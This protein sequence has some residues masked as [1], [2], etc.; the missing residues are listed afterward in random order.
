MP[1]YHP[2]I[3]RS[4]FEAL[5][6]SAPDAI[7]TIDDDSIV[8]SVNAAV[9]RVFGYTP[10]E[11]IGKSLTMLIPERLRAAHEGGIARYIRTG[12]KNIPWTG[13][14]LPGLTKDGREIPLE[15]SFG[16]FQDEQGRRVFS[17]FARD[18]SERARQQRELE[19]ARAVAENA[20]KELASVDRVMNIAMASG[21]YD[22][23]MRELVRGLRQEL[24]ADEATVLLTDK[25]QRELTIQVADGIEIGADVRIP[26][27]RGL[28]GRVAASG[29]PL[30]IEDLTTMEV[31]NPVLRAEIASLMAVPLRSDGELIGVV[32]VGTRARRQF[33]QFDVR[34]LEIVAERLSGVMAR[35]RLNAALEQQAREERILRGLAQSITAAGTVADAM[36]EIAEGA[37][38]LSEASGAFIEQVIA[39]N[40]DVEV[41]ASSGES[42]PHVGQRV[43]Y[44]GSLTEEIIKTRKPVFLLRLEGLGA[45]MAPYL[46]ERCHGCSA[47]VVP[48]FSEQGVLG[49]LVLLRRPGEPEF[50]QTVL[51]R[52]STLADLASLSLQRLVALAES[53]RR[54]GEA[55]AAVRSR[56]DVLSVVSHDLRNPLSTIAMSASLLG[57]RDIPLSADQQRK[58]VEI[59]GRSAQRMNRLIQDLLDVARI[60]GG[61]LAM[62]CRCEDVLALAREAVDAFRPIAEEKSLVLDCQVPEDAGAVLADRDRVLQLLSNFLNNAVKFSPRAGRITLRV[63]RTPARAVRFDVEDEGPG[64]AADHIPHVFGRFWQEKRTAHMG[65]GLGL[66]IARGIA[67]AHKGRVWVE[68]T[69]GRGSVFSFEL[70]FTE[71]C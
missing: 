56:D 52:L 9:E 11:L 5:A 54:R 50:T 2:E 49:A 36:R 16:E 27:G 69:P 48:L 61:R 26:L 43:P 13:A 1:P 34:L 12:R 57:D 65:S 58:Q 40:A 28:A 24:G 44:P 37:I 62:N 39:P 19:S 38:A 29:K 22:R 33:S 47:F 30:V 70:P 63:T 31:V 53:E 35:A 55:E 64:I 21:T 14:Q 4:Q 66:A 3:V 32:H 15:I 42:T 10:D 17:G 8:L 41:V 71:G 7:F 6:E 60:E 51:D 46:D 68:S 67:E 25:H 45:A 18:V 23:L 59:I 20:L